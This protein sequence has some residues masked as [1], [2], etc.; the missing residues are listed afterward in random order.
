MY[1]INDVVVYGSQ[2]V[3]RITDIGPLEM[4]GMENKSYYT[5]SPLFQNSTIIYAPVDNPKTVLRPVSSPDQMQDLI[6]R[7]PEI[8]TIEIKNDRERE[9]VYKAVIK[10][11]DPGE[12]LRLIKTI[13]QRRKDRLASGKKRIIIDEKYCQIAEEQL[14]QEMAYVMEENLDSM[15]EYFSEKVLKAYN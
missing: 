6:S 8:P 2:G 12:L 11:G 7:V 4:K 13:S 5:L 9:S 15:E 1:N 14:Y 3:C 10:T